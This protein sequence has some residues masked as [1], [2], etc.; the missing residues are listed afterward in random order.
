MKHIGS[1]RALVA[2]AEY[3]PS[4]RDKFCC[5]FY[6]ISVPHTVC[7]SLNTF[8][9]FSVSADSNY[10]ETETVVIATLYIRKQ[11]FL[12]SIK[13]DIK[14]YI[15]AKKVIGWVGWIKKLISD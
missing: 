5:K 12:E 6:L 11:E 7:L 10:E 3:Y 8:R 9:D 14:K 13:F 4:V 15:C 2:I 1:F